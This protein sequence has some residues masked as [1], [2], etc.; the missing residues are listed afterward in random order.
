MKT[1]TNVL[2]IS[3]NKCFSNRLKAASVAFMV[4]D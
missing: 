4:A 3:E 1:T 2:G